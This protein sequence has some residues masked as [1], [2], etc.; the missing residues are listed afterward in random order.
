MSGYAD[1]LTKNLRNWIYLKENSAYGRR[2]ANSKLRT[3]RVLARNGVSVPKLIAVFKSQTDV[4]QFAWE[5]LNDNFVVKPAS[6]SGGEGILVVRKRAK[7]AGEWFL[8]DGRKV[9]IAYLRFHCLDILQGQFNVRGTQDKVFIEERIKIHPKF[10]RFTKLGTPDVRVIV[11]NHVPVMAML[12]IPTEESKGKANLHQGA[13]GLGIDLATGI[14]TYGVHNGRLINKIY[15]RK[16][17]KPVKINGIRVPFWRKI[18][19]TA[20]LCQEAIPGLRFLGVDL[21]LDKEKG[22]VVLELNARPGL[23]IQICNRAGLRRR[24]ERVSGLKIRSVAH[25]IRV[26]QTLFGESFVDR[27]TQDGEIKVLDPLEP[28]KISGFEQGKRKRVEL[29]A[30]ID[31]G[32][33]RSSIDQ[34]LAQELGLLRPDNILYYRHYRSALGRRHRRPVIGL[35]LWIKGRKIITAAN[36]TDRHRLRTKILIGRKDLKGFMVRI[37]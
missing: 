25:G 31:T 27:V 32:A 29:M 2:I 36:V 9:D 19:E 12:R 7:W 34:E 15:D 20:I 21:V 5:K 8:M 18:L 17:K 4:F 10:L 28:V 6:S 11:Y 13:I 1:I 23:S 22:P 30:K 14:T 33:Y 37:D 3:K 16:R 35:T 24:L 26:A